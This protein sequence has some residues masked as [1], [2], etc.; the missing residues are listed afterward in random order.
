MKTTQIFSIFRLKTIY[1]ILPFWVVA[2]LC[3]SGCVTFN[4]LGYYL[5]LGEAMIEKGDIISH[6]VF[7]HTFFGLQYVN[8]GWLS[9]V[10]L[11][12][13][14]K[15]GGLE[16]LILLKTALLLVTMGVLY[17]L[18]FKR[19]KNEKVSLL[20]SVYAVA[21]GVSNWGIRPQLFVLPIFALFYA[22]LCLRE[23]ITNAAIA[24]LSLSMVLWVNLH[25]SFPLGLLLVG[26]FLLG[27]AVQK[28]RGNGRIRDLVADPSLRRLL[29]LLMSLTLVTLINP[30]GLDVWKDVWANSSISQ[31]RSAEW[32]RTTM[33][34]FLGYGFAVSIVITILM[35]AFGRRR[36]TLIEVILLLFFLL[37]GFKTVRMVLWW[38]MV[39]APIL[40]AQFC[41]LEPVAARLS[42]QAPRSENECLPVNILF[43]VV[44]VVAV[45][46]FLPWLRPYHPIAH[47]RNL[48]DPQ[49]E[50]VQIADYIEREGLKG[51]MYNDPNWGSYLI[52]RLW[53]KYQVFADNRIHLIPEDIWGDV[54]D[55][56][57]GLGNWDKVLD[58]Y[59][60]SWLVLSK[61]D[62][63]RTIEF[64]RDHPKWKNVYEDEVGAIFVR[65]TAKASEFHPS[66][67]GLPASGS[68][69]P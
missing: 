8:S 47:A 36:V 3:L 15:G 55:V 46:S 1:R 42:R 4:D 18:I 67:E 35:L 11:A 23:R 26:T 7:T 5:K 69:L 40:A 50:P 21:L 28:Y 38:G 63:R 16:L 44:M 62:N 10:L 34:G 65:S 32:Q 24:L 52:W 60:V 68:L 33:N 57:Y 51:K 49:T 2:V 27:E 29:F 56:H 20:F 19:T 58:K 41:S 12:M 43:L 61:V 17:H 45:I 48:V 31:A 6:D 37:A 59:D 14:E 53:P 64:I 25:S 39:S 13:V 66:S 22:F 9:Q 54:S 30:Y